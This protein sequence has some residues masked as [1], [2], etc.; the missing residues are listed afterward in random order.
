MLQTARRRKIHIGP[1]DH[2]RRMSLDDFDRAIGR[3]GYIYELGRGVIEVSELPTP[4]HFG[5][6]EEL[7]DQFY[8]YKLGR[9]GIIY[10]IASS[11]EAKILLAAYESERHPDLSI[12]LGPPP[13]VD[14][15]SLW[16]PHI[17][18][19][20]VS[21]SSRK[22]DYEVKPSE[23]VEFGVDE[24]WIIDAAKKQM[25][26]HVRWRGQW[27]TQI[28]KP[29]KKYSTRWLPGFSLDLKRVIAAAASTKTKNGRNGGRNG[30]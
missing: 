15:W 17:V 13:E 4:Q 6:V 3:E 19:E 9:K 26:V 20:V 27:K 30:K 5:Q 1:E 29:P 11:N 21:E 25:T 22:R 12:Y 7:K 23:Y 28:V 10:A 14:F 8:R 24:Y 2:G 16:V 18:I